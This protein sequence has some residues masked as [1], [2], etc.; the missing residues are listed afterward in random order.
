MK[1]LNGVFFIGLALLVLACQNKNSEVF[2]Y[3]NYLSKGK[4]KEAESRLNEQLADDPQNDKLLVQLETIR[5]LRKEFPYTQ[6][7][8]KE[9]LHEYFPDITDEDLKQ[10]ENAR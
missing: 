8:V 5:R 3:Q 2:N 7:D 9:Q 1:F 4:F 10:W 6:A